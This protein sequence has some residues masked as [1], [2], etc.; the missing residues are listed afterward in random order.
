MATIKLSWLLSELADQPKQGILFDQRDWNRFRDD[1][2]GKRLMLPVPAYRTG[3][4]A[5]HPDAKHVIDYL[6]Y[7]AKQVVDQS[8]KD[9]NRFNEASGASLT[10]QD[11]AGY[12]DHFEKTFG[13]HSKYGRP[14]CSWF[15]ALRDGLK[16]DLDA[17]VAEWRGLM[18]QGLEGYRD[19]VW[20]LYSR[21][22]AIKPKIPADVLSTNSMSDTARKFVLEEDLV[23]PDL[24]KWE[25]LKASFAFKHYNRSRF[26]WQM[27]GRQ[28]KAIKALAAGFRDTSGH[29]SSLAAP[30]PVVPN[31]Y[32]ALRPDNAYIKRAMAFEGDDDVEYDDCEVESEVL[33]GLPW[34]SSQET[35][36]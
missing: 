36:C 23:A 25:L 16:A 28:L 13:D 35:D 5:L 8:L 3:G 33:E 1:I 15:V 29:N 30:V 4:N 22:R 31:I 9:L 27:A 17:C 14:R 18:G 24:T 11:V 26:V 6:M 21:W 34:S 19:K 7:A 32:V 10:D 20:H 12:W 2:V